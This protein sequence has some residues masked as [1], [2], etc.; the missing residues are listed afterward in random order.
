M[1]STVTAAAR[2]LRGYARSRLSL[3]DGHRLSAQSPPERPYRAKL[4]LTYRCNLRCGFCYTDSPRRTLER[5][6]ELDDTSWHR[7]V[8]QSIELGIGEAGIIGGEPLLRQD[9][10]L[11]AL[12]RLDQAGL[13][14]TSLT[15][16]G[17][18]I[19]EALADRLARGAHP[20]G[21]HVNRRSHA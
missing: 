15:T 12:E 2:A 14:R 1:D 6:P 4:E 16:N 5:T 21:L 17:W 11:E 19:D 3:V 9:L 13:D 20:S 10:A 7:I 8:E 18:F